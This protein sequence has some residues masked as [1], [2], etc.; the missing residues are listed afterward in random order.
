MFNKKTFIA[1]FIGTFALVLIGITAIVVTSRDLVGISLAFGLTLAT[2]AVAYGRV[3]GAHFNPAVT[4]AAA[5]KGSLKWVEAVF[6][7]IAQFA[8]GILAIFFL[9]TMLQS[10]G[11]DLS[12][13]GIEGALT[14]PQPV[15]AM[16]VEAILS[17]FLITAYQQALGKDTTPAAWV[18]GAALTFTTL[19]GFFLTGG[20]FNPAR[21][22]ATAIFTPGSLSNVYTYVIYFF[23]PL[24]GATLAVIVANF[25]E[26]EQ[27]EE[28]VD[29][30]E[31]DQATLEETAA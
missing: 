16:V 6:Y 28:E 4:F 31:S 17:F 21:A 15:F 5:L 30:D 11:G 3:S 12:G 26:E 18:I 2:F 9:K 23:G 20:V 27:D 22:L 8:G 19:V 10:L 29:E 13:A 24:L 7:W 1:E 25:L 14:V